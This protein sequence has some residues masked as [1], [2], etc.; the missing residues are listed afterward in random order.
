MKIGM[1]TMEDYQ[2]RNIN[3]VGSSRIRG[4][5]LVKYWDNLEMYKMGRDYGA[6]IYQK[7]YWENMMEKFGG[8][9]ILD[10]CDPDWLEGRDVMRFCRMV[11][12]VVTASEALAEYIRQF[13]DKPVVCIPDRLDLDEFK[14]EPKKQKGKLNSVVWFGY[15]NN[16]GYLTYALP[17]LIDKGIFNLTVISDAP[18]QVP[19]GL[20]KVS[21]H[22][23]QYQ[24]ELLNEELIKYDAAFLPNPR[25]LKIDTKGRYKTN[26][27][28]LVCMAIGLPVISEPE[29]LNRFDN[30]A[31][32]EA[33]IQAGY[34]EVVDKY[35]VRLSVSA[36]KELITKLG[37]ERK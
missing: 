11:D 36:Y 35:D 3:T 26:N 22:N 18:Y 20:S 28:E 29:D 33:D 7:V 21:V 1:M 16:F 13:V 19:G 31:E 32:R 4:R 14:F 12:A 37:G 34:K 10:I 6:I 2:N 25:K 17:A 30:P 9:Q 5:W 15:H 8:L 23:V 24:Q 27:K